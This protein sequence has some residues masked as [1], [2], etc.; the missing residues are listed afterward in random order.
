MGKKL[1]VNIVSE[2]VLSVQGH[3]VHTAYEEM[4]RSL[5]AR[6]DIELIR[7]DFGH[8]TECDVV[9]F[10]TIGPR[11]FK[12]LF[13]KGPAKVI[14]AHVVPDSFVGSLV[15]AR[16][17][18]PLASRYLRWFYSRADALL[19]VSDATA[20]ELRALKVEAPIHVL[21]NSIDTRRYKQVSKHARATVRK[22]LGIDANTFVVIGGGQVQ[23]RKRVD[24]FIKAAK[25]LPGVAFV[26]VGGIPFGRAAAGHDEM[27]KL[28][29][30]KLPNVYF[31]GQVELDEMVDFYHSA[32]LFW[33]PS[34]QET[35]GLVVIEAAASGLPVLLRDI[36]DYTATFG[37]NVY[38]AKEDDFVHAIR[39]FEDDTTL[40][41]E[42]TAKAAHLAAKFD[43]ALVADQLVAIYRQLVT[44]RLL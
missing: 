24:L 23:P 34:E 12:K 5:E 10:H 39:R 27:K 29:E 19:A 18:K 17:W 13:Q 32:D 35:F 14:S 26:W 44:D 6:S 2:S 15:G 25:E 30:T 41:E 16:F 37:D 8:R 36:E 3:G 1:R 11:T 4:A 20:E 38:R 43:S 9:H 28:M 33:L 40:R 31:P 7:N 22:R 42:Y 21:Y